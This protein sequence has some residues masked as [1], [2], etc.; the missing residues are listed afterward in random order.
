MIIDASEVFALAAKLEANAAEAV[1]LATAEVKKS[2]N[3]VRQDASARA[4]EDTGVMAG[5]ITV[6]MSGSTNP[7][8]TI[9]A[10]ADYSGFV[11]FGTSSQAPQPYLNP[12]FDAVVPI[13]AEDLGKI[14][15]LL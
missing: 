9:E 13:F 6:K 15:E 3:E 7:K 10:T 11:E 14:A 5:A 12:A 4:P 2:G 1:T 8:A